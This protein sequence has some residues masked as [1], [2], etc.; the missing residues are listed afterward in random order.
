MP[1]DS[2]PLPREGSEGLFARWKAQD[3]RGQKT[4]SQELAQLRADATVV[5]NVHEDYL[6]LVASPD[7]TVVV[8]GVRFFCVSLIYLKVLFPQIY[9][10]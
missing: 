6:D 3:R 9:P 1:T 7:M 2:K 4:F 5:V 10:S 8:L